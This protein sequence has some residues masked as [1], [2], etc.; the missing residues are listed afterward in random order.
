MYTNLCTI[1]LHKLLA[2]YCLI[3]VGI[4]ADK[5][6]DRQKYILLTQR[7]VITGIICHRKNRDRCLCT[8]IYKMVNLFKSFDNIHGMTY[9][10]KII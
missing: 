10:I 3:D 4:V 7:K 1:L 9:R 6:T 2:I 8:C 5:Q